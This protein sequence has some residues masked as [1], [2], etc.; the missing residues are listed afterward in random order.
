MTNSNAD[1]RLKERLKMFE[2]IDNMVKIDKLNPSNK[3]LKD[4]Q[5][6]L[7]NSNL[8]NYSDK[9]NSNLDE[10]FYENLNYPMQSNNI[11]ENSKNVKI[12]KYEN[13]EKEKIKNNENNIN[14]NN[15]NFPLSTK[16]CKFKI[17]LNKNNFI[18]KTT[19]FSNDININ[20]LDNNF[21]SSN[22]QNLF[23]NSNYKNLI[24]SKYSSKSPQRKNDKI[25]ENII[26]KNNNNFYNFPNQINIKKELIN[27]TTNINI[28]NNSPDFS[29]NN[30]IYDKDKENPF[31]NNIIDHEKNFSYNKQREDNNLT[32][33]K[34]ENFN[35]SKKNKFSYKSPI[36]KTISNQKLQKSKFVNHY[37][38]F[39][40]G[41]CTIKLWKT[42]PSIFI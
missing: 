31:K 13:L 34:K 3:V 5:S 15:S 39:K 21:V 8:Y 11:K 27:P 2:E 24:H 14:Y 28:R 19:N 7:D 4:Q 35:S 40:N 30:F 17:E 1:I 20:K 9:I 22:N 29:I 23:K 16:D 10:N 32:K 37:S 38:I 26:T 33:I 18:N 12:Q 6:Q 41:S 42:N 25:D 36:I